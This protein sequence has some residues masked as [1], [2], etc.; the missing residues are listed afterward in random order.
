M[1]KLR[2]AGMWFL[3]IPLDNA[4]TKAADKVGVQIIDYTNGAK[5]NSVKYL[6]SIF[7][8]ASMVKVTLANTDNTLVAPHKEEIGVYIYQDALPTPTPTA[9][10]API[11]TP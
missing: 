1:A 8:S 10:T 3:N 5:A 2:S 9:T 6:S 7:T 4:K 11:A